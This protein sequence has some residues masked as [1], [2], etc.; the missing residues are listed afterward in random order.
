MLK[1]IIDANL[2]ISFLI[3]KRLIDLKKLCFDEN[4]SVIAC[5]KIVEEFID[6]SSREKIR[7]YIEQQNISDILTLIKVR[8]VADPVEN[9]VMP[10]LRDPD[11]LYLLALADAVDADFLLT[12]DKDLLVLKR[13][14][15]T[16]IISYSEFMARLEGFS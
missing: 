5:P 4:I 8:C 13:Y 2:W 3:G 10:D 14:N 1:I 9:V 15:Q 7:K 12:G 11:D 16:E 6:V